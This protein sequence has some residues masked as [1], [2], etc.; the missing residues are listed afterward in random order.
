MTDQLAVTRKLIA[1]ALT[2]LVT[3]LAVRC[4]DDPVG[5][6]GEIRGLP[7][8]LTGAEQ[9]L[10]QSDNAFGLKLFREIQA[11]EEPGVNLFISPLSVAM[12]LGMTYNGAAGTTYE[13]MQETLELQGLTL[14]EVNES[15]RTLIDL[16][17]GLDPSVQFLLANSI[18]YREGYPVRPQFL[19]VNQ[20]YFDAEVAALDFASPDAAPTINGWVS[21]KTNGRIEEIVEDP[22]AANTV[23]FLINAIYF[24]GDWTLQ[25]DPEL[26]AD[27]PFYLAH[28]G[29]KQ[30]PM[31][32]YPDAVDVGY[33]ADEGVVALDLAYG[34]KAYSMTILMPAG[35]GDIAALVQGLDTERWASIVAGLTTSELYVVMPKF[36]LEYELEMNDVLKALGMEIA[37][38]P[39]ADFSKIAPG[40]WIDKVKHKSFVE[41]NEEGTEAAA[42]TS[43]QMIDSAPL[44]VVVDR[45]FLFA[46]RERYSG[47]ILFMGLIMDPPVTS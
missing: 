30:V 43:V 46:I 42:V 37:F 47:T 17:A 35:D 40:I 33:Y 20:E 26:T 29:Q 45:P 44:A 12:A 14:D 15:Y 9:E 19:A 8:D 36:T 25:F 1:S 6:L 28:G 23:M 18:W 5:P 11:Q 34:G 2:L 7:R 39:G 22:I 27:R 4:S 38:T 31:M 13:A 41:V 10:I 16:L 32:T 21:E 24:K 3:A